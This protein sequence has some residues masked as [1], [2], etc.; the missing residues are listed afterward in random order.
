MIDQ[1][2]EPKSR[3]DQD[4]LTNAL[5]RMAEEDPTFRMR[6]DEDSG[7]TIISGMGELHLDVITDRMMREFGVQ[8][9]IG[10]PQVAY[11]ETIT[12]PSHVDHTFKRQTGGKGQFAHVVIDVTPQEQGKGYEFESKIVGGVYPAR[13]HPGDRQGYPRL[14]RNRVASLAIRWSMSR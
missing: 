11:R 8:A 1:S 14:A 7:Q 5:L 6:T 10:K 9:N 2:I 3:G 12:R 13:V 4:K